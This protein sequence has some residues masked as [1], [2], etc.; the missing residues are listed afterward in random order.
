MLTV[1]KVTRLNFP[2]VCDEVPLCQ[3][4]AMA[5]WA[6]CSDPFVELELRGGYVAQ[7][8]RGKRLGTR[9]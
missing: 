7:E 2:T 6:R 8:A 1:V 5:A 9:D 4:W 3:C